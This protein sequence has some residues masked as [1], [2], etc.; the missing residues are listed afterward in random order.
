MQ[1]IITIYQYIKSKYDRYQ[2]IKY[3]DKDII[4]KFHDE[5]E[6]KI[7]LQNYFNIY[8]NDIFY[9]NVDWQDIKDTIDDFFSNQYAFCEKNNKLKI[10][11]LKDYN[12]NAND[13]HVWTIEKTLK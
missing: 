7:S 5:F 11:K 8:F 2:K 12:V 3:T 1:D 6:M 13:N 9:Y 10:I 4:I